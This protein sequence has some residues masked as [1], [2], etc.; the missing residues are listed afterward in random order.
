[1]SKQHGAR[2][3]KKLA[4]QKA[5]RESRRRQLVRLNSPDPA[6]RLQGADHWPV[7]AGARSPG[8]S[9]TAASAM[10]CSRAPGL[11]DG[12]V[13]CAV[14]LLDVFCLGV[15]R[16]AFWRIL[17]LPRI[18]PSCG[19]GSTTGSRC[20]V[21][22]RVSCEAGVPNGRLRPIAGLPA[23]PGFPPRASA[24]GRARRG[25]LLRRVSIQPGRKAALHFAV[26]A[27]M[28]SQK[29]ETIAAR[30]TQHGGHYTVAAQTRRNASP[31][32]LSSRRSTTSLATT[33]PC[34]DSAGTVPF[35][36][37]LGEKRGLSLSRRRQF[38]PVPSGCC[39]LQ[40]EF[41]Y[42]RELSC[43]HGEFLCPTLLSQ[44]VKSSKSQIFKSEIT[45]PSADAAPAADARNC[46]LARLSY[47]G[48]TRAQER[49][50]HRLPNAQRSRGDSDQSRL[51][52]PTSE[53]R[54]AS[55]AV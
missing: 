46:A 8:I 55:V 2:E 5:K 48:V 20:S 44:I 31:C 42:L 23:A 17:A 53:A 21:A 36:G 41:A 45:R 13:A 26:P 29:L 51:G 15:E 19:S 24:A 40:S 34:C 32:P 38:P 27:W 18:S 22:P 1:M 3:Q 11:P 49:L 14:F 12:Q 16:R 33:I 6:V 28:E 54:R 9:G 4:K 25:P 30:L 52:C 7:A 50:P 37:A 10:Q 39:H 43:L 47:V 35:F